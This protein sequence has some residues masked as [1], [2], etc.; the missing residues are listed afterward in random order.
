MRQDDWLN[1]QEAMIARLKGYDEASLWAYNDCLLEGLVDEQ[2][3]DEFYA[4]YPT[5]EVLIEMGLG[6]ETGYTGHYKKSS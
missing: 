1:S 2:S 4:E 5:D 3:F 6:N